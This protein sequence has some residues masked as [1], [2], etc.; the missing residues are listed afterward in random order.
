[1]YTIIM[2]YLVISVNKVGTKQTLV[3]VCELGLNLQSWLISNF[4]I[5]WPCNDFR[6]SNRNY[7]R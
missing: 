2:I 6:D 7:R 1:M 5:S 3:K 4:H